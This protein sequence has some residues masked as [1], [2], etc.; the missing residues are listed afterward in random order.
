MSYDFSGCATKYNV[1]CND[2][3]VITPQAF[4]EDNGITVPLVWHHRHD[5]PSNVLGKARLENRPD[6]MYAHCEFNDSQSAKDAKIGVQHGDVVALSIYANNLIH[7]GCNVTHGHIREVSLVLAG[8]NPGALILPL[9]IKHGDD[10]YQMDSEADIYSGEE[11][12]VHS[13]DMDDDEELIVHSDDMDDDKE[14]IE[15]DSMA[16]KADNSDRTVQDVLNEMTEEQKNVV[17]FLIGEAVDAARNDEGSKSISHADQSDENSSKSVGKSGRT[18]QDVLD[19]MTEE[20]KN[21][22]AFL[23]GTAVEEATKGGAVKHSDF[24]EDDYMAYN[25]FE[26][27]NGGYSN[28]EFIRHEDMVASFKDAKDGTFGGSLK[29]NCLAHE[30]RDIDVLMPDAHLVTS[31]PELISRENSWVNDFWGAASKRPFSKIK[32]LAA[33]ITEYEARAKGYIKG[34]QKAE[35]VFN[36]LGRITTPQTVYKL[37]K[38]DRDDII[39][40]ED[41]D[42]VAFM[43]REMQ[44]MLLEEIARAGL[45]GDDRPSSDRERISPEHIRPIYKDDDLY[46][47]HYK[48][49]LTSASTFNDVT[50]AIIQAAILARKNFKGSG[51]PN[52]YVSPD[53]VSRMLL[54]ED[55]LGHR[56]YD[57]ETKLASALRVSK[58]VE[59]P[60][61]DGVTRTAQISTTSGGTTVTTSEDRKLLAIIVNPADYIF[62]ANKGGQTTLFDDFDLNFNKYEYLYE[63]RCCGALVK[64]FS[65]I[66][67]ETAGDLPFDFGTVSG[68]YE[69]S[70]TQIAR[71]AVGTTGTTGSTGN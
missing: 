40:I 34:D 14:E 2:G 49:D 71:A 53:I 37:Q 60:I 54:A 62:G 5:S 21:V 11:I 24:M 45:I 57:D 51:R 38:L 43:K 36:V 39:D 17:A 20:Q 41:F 47:I 52:M 59:V 61:F 26:S 18:V 7:S 19:E 1:K 58:I 70:A 65:A 23:I 69:G 12:I 44:T 9:S 22:L 50:R 68:M 63:T 64:P 32:S 6:G 3:R 42:V 46:T 48:V 56:L 28:D 8:C 16:G 25:A 29:K 35:E 15:E 4:Q 27:Q 55:T 66:A 30:I 31:G 13:D 33:N 10:E 67:I